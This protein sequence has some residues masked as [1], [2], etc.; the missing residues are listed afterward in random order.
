MRVQK[1]LEVFLLE[2]LST[3][4]VWGRGRSSATE[5]TVPDFPSFL[6]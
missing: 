1:S 4:V 2:S 5:Y 3:V 6:R